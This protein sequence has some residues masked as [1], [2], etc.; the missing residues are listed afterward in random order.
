M[1]PVNSTTFKVKK[2]GNYTIFV[3]AVPIG[4]KLHSDFTQQVLSVSEITLSNGLTLT[5]PETFGNS[6][7]KFDYT[8]DEDD[9]LIVTATP[10]PYYFYFA[11][12]RAIDL[13]EE[14]ATIGFAKTNKEF[15]LEKEYPDF[16]TFPPSLMCFIIE[17]I[18]SNAVP[19]TV[20]HNQCAFY[21]SLRS[22][23]PDHHN[24]CRV[25]C[26]DVAL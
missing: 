25:F 12:I 8:P 2:G 15:C 17:I 5:D 16:S 24:I 10:S 11:S 23:V 18:K 9:T 4:L 3:N 19:R 14:Y 13:N 6:I 26:G 22:A 20:V 21:R 7:A 1:H